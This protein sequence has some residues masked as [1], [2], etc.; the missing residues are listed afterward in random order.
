MRKI[1]IAALAFLGLFAVLSVAAPT[2]SAGEYGKC[3]FDS[4]CRGQAKCHSGT[5]SDAPG[6]TCNFESEC[7]GRHCTGGHCQ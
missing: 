1:S 2:A 3:N 4:D 5:C 7:N 6:G